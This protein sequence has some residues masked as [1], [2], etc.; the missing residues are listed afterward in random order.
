[1]ATNTQRLCAYRMRDTFVLRGHALPLGLWNL[2]ICG[3][4]GKSSAPIGVRAQGRSLP[5]SGASP[6]TSS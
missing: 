5:I 3:G 4:L 6:P 1:M 2:C